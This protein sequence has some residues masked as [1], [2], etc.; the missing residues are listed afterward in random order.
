[1]A[2]HLAQEVFPEYRVGLLHGRMKADAKDRVVKAFARGRA[3]RPGVDDR[4]RSR[5]GCAECQRDGRRARRAL[6][7]V[8]VASAA[9]PRR[10][11]RAP[12]LLL[13]AVS[14]A[15]V[16]RGAQPSQG[17]HRNDRRFA[18]RG[19]RPRAARARAISSARGRPAS[20]RSARSICCAIGRCSTMRIARRASWMDVGAPKPPAV[21]TAARELA[22]RV[23]G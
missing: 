23:S 15:A 17:A 9:R 3:R 11:R 19:A 7:P 14:G 18:D 20:R 13:P 12:V 5:R 22:E 4:R 10:P 2:D 8:A 21:A 6:R 16:G 1:M